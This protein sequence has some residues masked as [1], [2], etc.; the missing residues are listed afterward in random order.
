MKCAFTALIGLIVISYTYAQ[1]ITHTWNASAVN[2][3]G[4]YYSVAGAETPEA[5]N[6]FYNNLKK[7]NGGAD[8]SETDSAQ[9]VLSYM[10]MMEYAAGISISFDAEGMV[11][12]TGHILNRKELHSETGKYKIKGST[13]QTN[14]KKSKKPDFEI[15]ALSEN[16]LV[17]NGVLGSDKFAVKFVRAD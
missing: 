1:T 9:S 2:M 16:E 7:Q 6:T 3:Y 11:V 15:I 12:Y 8:M 10:I 14:L 4:N 13:I 17:L 5:I